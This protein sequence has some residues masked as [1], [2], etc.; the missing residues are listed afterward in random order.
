[1]AN[2]QLFLN[3]FGSV[4]VASVKNAPVTGTPA[5]ELDYGILRLSDGAAGVLLNP[6]G[7]DYY[8]LTSFKKVGTLESSIEIMRV[9]NVNNSVPGECRVTVL[10][11]QEGTPVQAYVSGDFVA[12]RWTKGG[13]GNLLQAQANLSDLPSIPAA[14][15][16][17]ALENVDNTP[18]TNKPVSTAQAASIATKEASANKDASGGYAGLTLFRLNLRNA[19]NTIT[20]F[21]TNAATV[22]RTYT[23]QNRD[24]TLAD[25]TDLALKAN[26]AN[27]TFTGTV[28]GITKTMVGL[29]NADNTSDVNKP[30]ST[31]QAAADASKQDLTGKDSSGGYAGLTLFAHNMRNVANTFTSLLTN[32]ATAARTWTLPDRT[33]TLADNTDLALKANLASPTFTGTVAG[34]TA[35]MVGGG[36]VGS[37][38]LAAAT[39]L[40]AENA[41]G[42]ARSLAGSGYKKFADGSILQ[43]GTSVIA[44]NGAGGFAISYPI[45]FP[46][47]AF[48]GILSNGDIT[49]AGSI[50][51][52]AAQLGLGSI[53]GIASG[54]IS[55]TIRVNWI[56][57]GN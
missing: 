51:S 15:A 57:I 19:A 5:T 39:N 31:A 6:T 32:T 54:A 53:G 47:A 20:S 41:M 14:K 40:A 50:A 4:F 21:L 45:S 48:T 24:G 56:A 42:M 30:V 26:L 9:T 52:I 16:T 10:R 43:W 25:D 34:I 12:M 17:L 11:G 38:V 7:G 36:A 27:P 18:D 35:A 55:T 29:S 3:N 1:M 22:A 49:Y 28:A 37:A 2:M 44:T 8:I 33:G 13:V 46:T 23:L